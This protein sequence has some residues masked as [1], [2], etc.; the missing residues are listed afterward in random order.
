MD[1]FAKP[2]LISRTASLPILLIALGVFGGVLAFGFIGIFLGPVLLALG[3]VLAEKWT[4]A[5]AAAAPQP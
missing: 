2:L 4:A 3:L 1:N 5:Q